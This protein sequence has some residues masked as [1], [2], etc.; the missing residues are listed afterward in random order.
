MAEIPASIIPEGYLIKYE[1]DA[2]L[3]KQNF[4]V[5]IPAHTFYKD[6]NIEFEVNGK[7]NDFWR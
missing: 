1:K 4:S 5:F 3:E 7:R 2:A 6:H